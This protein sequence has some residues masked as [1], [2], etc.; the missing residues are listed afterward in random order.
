MALCVIT[1]KTAHTQTHT[2]RETSLFVMSWALRA[3]WTLIFSW[4]LSWGKQP[5]THA[6]TNFQKNAFK[7]W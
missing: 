3:A 2:K 1:D 7:T 6:D 5:G 4:W